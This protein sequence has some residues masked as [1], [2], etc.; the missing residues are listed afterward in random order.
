MIKHE[1]LMLGING[2]IFC[3]T[4]IFVHT[5]SQDPQMAGISN[6]AWEDFFVYFGIIHKIHAQFQIVAFCRRQEIT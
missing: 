3:I 5:V 2:L 1:N 6:F 4:R